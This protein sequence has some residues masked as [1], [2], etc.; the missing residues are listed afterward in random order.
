MGNKKLGFGSIGLL[1]LG[2][3]I[4]DYFLFFLSVDFRFRIIL[5]FFLLGLFRLFFFILVFFEVDFSEM[6]LLF[7]MDITVILFFFVLYCLELGEFF[8]KFIGVGCFI[9]LLVLFIGIECMVVV[10][11]DKFVSLNIYI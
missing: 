11:F 5:N 7:D 3:F 1:F 4:D 9:F 8:F 2:F 10:F 6:E